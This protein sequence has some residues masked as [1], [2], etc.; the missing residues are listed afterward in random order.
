MEAVHRWMRQLLYFLNQIWNYAL[1][2]TH[3]LPAKVFNTKLSVYLVGMTVIPLLLTTAITGY[4]GEKAL[5]EL[6]IDHN[7]NAALHTAEDIDRMFGEKIRIL[8]MAAATSEIKSM[9][10]EKQLPLLK[11]IEGQD[12]DILIVTTADADGNLIARSDAQPI[13]RWI[14]YSNNSYFQN[15]KQAGKTTISDVILSKTTGYPSIVIAQPIQDEQQKIVGILSI[16]VEL[17]TVMS[18]STEQKLVKLDIF[19][20]LIKTAIFW[21]I[22]TGNWL[23]VRMMFRSGLRL[24]PLWSKRLGG[25]NMKLIDKKNWLPIAISILL[26]GG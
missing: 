23:L 14:N 24:R 8:R 12:A 1:L 4:N 3:H 15:A 10:S 20:L 13:E 7:W 17:R 18:I 2:P 19:I 16:T 22:L 6:V 5:I 25:Q 9:I 21:Y 26:V 11:S